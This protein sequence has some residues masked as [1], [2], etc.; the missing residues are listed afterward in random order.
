M[1]GRYLWDESDEVVGGPDHPGR[2]GDPG[3]VNKKASSSDGNAS[4]RS[5]VGELFYILDRLCPNTVVDF[6]RVLFFR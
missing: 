6:L 5:V 2:R 3:S 1:C 4:L